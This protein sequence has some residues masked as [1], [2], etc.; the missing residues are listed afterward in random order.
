M[1]F[2]LFL[3][4]VGA[5]IYIKVLVIPK[6]KHRT[7]NNSV[8]TPSMDSQYAPK[9]RNAPVSNDDFLPDY[10]IVDLET[11]GLHYR[12]D[13]IIQFAALRVRNHM[14]AESLCFVV[15]PGIP[16]SPE[17]SKVNGFTDDDVK[18]KEPFV[19]HIREVLDFIGDDVLVGHNLSGF[20]KAFIEYTL[21]EALMNQCLDTLLLAQEYIRGTSN[22]KLVTLYKE[23]VGKEPENAHDAL[24]DCCMTYDVFQEILRNMG[25]NGIKATYDLYYRNLSWYSYELPKRDFTINKEA[26]ETL[27]FYKQSIV[28]SGRIPG[29][30]VREALQ[31]ICDQ[32]GD[33]SH[34]LRQKTT[35]FVKGIG[36]N[37]Y[38]LK[39]A[40][41]GVVPNKPI[42]IIDAEEFKRLAII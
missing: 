3:L 37:E 28:I 20:D 26:D 10:T 41:S 14:P 24:V 42:K 31:A 34:Q 7:S 33:F 32:G 36:V 27:P 13:R 18:D 38:L 17:A 16:I 29:M 1:G 23:L 21:G 2:F 40:E 9:K 25:R 19:R 11:T 39:Q 6:S 35:I 8:Y 30:T 5:I 15:N 22:H 4:F 12:Q